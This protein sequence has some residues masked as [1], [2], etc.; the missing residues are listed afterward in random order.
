MNVLYKRLSKIAEVEFPDIVHHSSITSGKLRL[1]ITDGS[2][3]DIWFSQKL[4]DRFAY[5]WERR[6]IDGKIYRYDN[7][8]HEQYRSMKGYPGHYHNGCDKKVEEDRFSDDYEVVLREFL[9]MVRDKI[10]G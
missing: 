7:R 6:K 3:F 4:P 8:P 10:K 2:Y 9:K 1:Y 5:H